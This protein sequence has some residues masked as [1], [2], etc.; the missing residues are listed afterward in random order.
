MNQII[1]KINKLLALGERGGTEAEATAAM[2][3]V[4]ELLAKHNLSL[5][6]VKESPVAEEDYVRDEAEA[7]ARQ[8]WQDWVWTAV[9]EL[10][11]C[12]HFKR[13]SCGEVTHLLIGKPSNIAV[14]K[15]VAGYVVRTGEELARRATGGSGQ[16]FRNSFKKGF[17]VRIA[18][19][20][21]EEIKIA[22][23]GE[24]KDSVTG[25]AL[26]LSPLYDRSSREIERFMMQQSM[27]P[28]NQ[29]SRASVSDPDGY[30]AGKEAADSVSLRGN[31]VGQKAVAAIGR[32]S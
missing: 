9:A 7:S 3:K 12:R 30:R 19:R 14:V 4:H 29:S 16:A 2:R 32:A 15:F 31:G 20:V 24:M 5:D 27:K 25:T 13:H 21:K 18:A 1:D 23:A 17:A 10:Y 6:D 22:K 26:V 11:F 28:R 8:P